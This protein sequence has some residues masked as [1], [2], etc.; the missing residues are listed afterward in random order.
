MLHI[1]TACCLEMLQFPLQWAEPLV[2]L[3]LKPSLF[4]F[5]STTQPCRKSLFSA[6]HFCILFCC[7][8]WC[9]QCSIA[10][11]YI[12]MLQLIS[13]RVLKETG[14]NSHCAFTL[15]AE[16]A[17]KSSQAPH[18][19]WCRLGPRHRRPG[20]SFSFDHPLSSSLEVHAGHPLDHL[21]LEQDQ[22]QTVW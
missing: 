12:M 20:C 15:F 2:S 22:Y 6:E 11:D 7:L 3:C 13:E 1:N 4:V 14:L 16:I 5:S 21:H 8:T 19:N 10:Y 9:L 17:S 18:H